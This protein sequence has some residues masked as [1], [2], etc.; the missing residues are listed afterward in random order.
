MQWQGSIQSLQR[1]I[2]YRE[3]LVR[4]EWIDQQWNNPSRTDHYLLQIARLIAGVQE[5]STV[6][7]LKFTRKVPER[8]P[9][10][11]RTRE[12]AAKAARAQWGAIIPLNEKTNGS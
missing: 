1:S 2:S 12:E 10:Q 7:P 5:P 8:E 6:G 4:L 9:I 11:P 3:F